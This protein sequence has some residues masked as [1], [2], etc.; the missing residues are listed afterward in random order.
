MNNNLSKLSKV[1]F[2]LFDFEGVLVNGSAAGISEFLIN[3]K[4]I[5]ESFNDSFHKLGYKTGIITA[6]ENDPVTES[7]NDLG[8]DKIFVSSFDKVSPIE[9]MLKEYNLQFEEL[10]YCGDDILDIPLM[11]KAGFTV[12]PADAKRELKRIA[13]FICENNGGEKILSEILNLIEE[14]KI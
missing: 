8:F 3:S 11:Q 1:K 13:D 12:C 14:S 7:L 9:K 5:V 2:L 6:R 4:N 10:L